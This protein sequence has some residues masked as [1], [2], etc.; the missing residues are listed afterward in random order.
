MHTY[1]SDILGA[2][3][4]IVMTEN[5]LVLNSYIVWNFDLFN[6]FLDY[7]KEDDKKDGQFN[8]ETV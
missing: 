1:S 8:R 4:T 7:L 3:L 5:G 2:Q 6:T